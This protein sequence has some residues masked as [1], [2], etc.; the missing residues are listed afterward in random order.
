VRSV[1]HADA[2]LPTGASCT[3]SRMVV[4]FMLLAA[5]LLALGVLMAR[6]YPR[7]I[8]IAEPVKNPCGFVPNA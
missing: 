3:V 2:R 5:I 4:D 1:P 8:L 7:A 6:H